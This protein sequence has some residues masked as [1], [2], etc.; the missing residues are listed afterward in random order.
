MMKIGPGLYYAELTKADQLCYIQL[1]Q[2]YLK[3]HI[4]KLLRNV[5]DVNE[6]WDI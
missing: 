5:S 3:I 4:E 6:I 1:Y 2:Y